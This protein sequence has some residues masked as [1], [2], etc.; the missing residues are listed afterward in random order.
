MTSKAFV[1]TSNPT[2]L[3]LLCRKTVCS[4]EI[5]SVTSNPSHEELNRPGTL[6]QS[7]NC[8]LYRGMTQVSTASPS[9]HASVGKRSGSRVAR[10]VWRMRWTGRRVVLAQGGPLPKPSRLVS[11]WGGTCRRQRPCRGRRVSVVR[12]VLLGGCC[13]RWFPW[14]A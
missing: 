4:R 6:A 1:R 7:Y 8:D 14:R 2:K 11:P 13:G 9:Q 12:Q 5:A 10:L 3:L